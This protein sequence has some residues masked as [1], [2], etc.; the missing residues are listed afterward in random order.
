MNQTTLF[1]FNDADNNI[2]VLNIYEYFYFLANSNSDRKE[3]TCAVSS[4]IVLFLQLVGVERM[5]RSQRRVHGQ[6]CKIMVLSRI[7]Y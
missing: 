2:L 1:F 5:E 6:L 3:V 4:L 7:P